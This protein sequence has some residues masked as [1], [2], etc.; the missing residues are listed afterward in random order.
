[1]RFPLG[2]GSVLLGAVRVRV[3]AVGLKGSHPGFAGAAIVKVGSLLDVGC[4]RTESSHG[5]GCIRGAELVDY[6][7][8]A[9]MAEG[10]GD[11][12]FVGVCLSLVQP[13]HTHRNTQPLVTQP[14]SQPRS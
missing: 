10:D 6:A 14:R 9:R 3:M 1:M 11:G 5:R 4:T 12:D 13:S 8:M 7:I 2:S